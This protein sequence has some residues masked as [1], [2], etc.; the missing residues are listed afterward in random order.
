MVSGESCPDITLLMISANRWCPPVRD[1]PP[2]PLTALRGSSALNRIV[3]R[4]AR[5]IRRRTSEGSAKAGPTLHGP[6]IFLIA[7]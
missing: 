4:A 2:C 1:N 3:G 5:R 6:P 7:G